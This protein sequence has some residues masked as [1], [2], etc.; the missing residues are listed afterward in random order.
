MKVMRRVIVEKVKRG[1]E[2]RAGKQFRVIR[3][4]NTLTPEVGDVLEESHVQAMINSGVDVV[5]DLPRDR[6]RKSA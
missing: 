4:V 6:D 5:V 2:D 1:Q 3:T